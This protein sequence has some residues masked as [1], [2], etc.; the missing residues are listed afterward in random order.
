M[1]SWDL[2]LEGTQGREELMQKIEDVKMKGDLETVRQQV[3]VGVDVFNFL[4][5]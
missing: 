1:I 3:P 2:T 5:A 4:V